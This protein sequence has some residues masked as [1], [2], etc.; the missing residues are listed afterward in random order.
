MSNKPN[1]FVTQLNL[2]LAEKLRQG[3]VDQGFELL[4][5]PH[6][7]FA[8]KKKGISCALYESG[9]LVVQGKET[10]EFVEFYL[11]PELL[12]DFSSSYQHL[13]VDT[14]SRIGIDESGKGDFF[15]PLCIAGVFADSKSIQAL[16]KLKVGDSKTFKDHSILAL[17]PKI[18]KCCVS[19]VIRINPIKYNELYPKFQNLNKLLAWGHATTIEKLVLATGCK[20]AIIDQFASEHVVTSALKQ[21]KLTI[22]LT[23]RTKA[24]EDIV[25]AAAS[26]LAREA[27]LLGL[28]KLSKEF[29]I[30]LPKGGASK[31][32]TKVGKQLIA[33]FGPD[34]CKQICK[35]HFK[36]FQNLF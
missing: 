19:H 9:K 4:Q 24:E 2:N 17:A 36:T 16:C 15:G 20:N 28:D 21:K 7:L 23:Q 22:N 3:L 12:K 31:G 11:E 10:S 1:T 8:G 6:T 25:V 13:Y 27:F 30:K 29:G 33:K 32:I 26:M 5:R 34:I 35:I 18:R 14:T